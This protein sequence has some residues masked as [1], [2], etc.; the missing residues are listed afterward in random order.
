MTTKKLKLDRE[1][2][3]AKTRGNNLNAQIKEM[4][5]EKEKFQSLI[6]F[7]ALGL[8]IIDKDGQILFASSDAKETF[9]NSISDN[10]KTLFANTK[11][12]DSFK[13]KEEIIKEEILVN[14]NNQEI[15]LDLSLRLAQDGGAIIS[16]SDLTYR[17][18]LELEKYNAIDDYQS[19]FNN[20]SEG[21]F[22]VALDGQLLKANPAYLKL[23]GVDSE[24]ELLAV[25]DFAQQLYVD[26]NRS[27]EFLRQISKTGQ[28]TGF[29][30]EVYAYKTRQRIWISEDTKAI[31]NEQGDTLYYDGICRD[32]ST[33]KNSEL[34][35][36]RWSRFQKRLIKVSKSLLKTGF[37]LKFYDRLIKETIK[38]L[39]EIQTGVLFLRNNNADFQAVASINCNIS[40]SECNFSSKGIKLPKRPIYVQ[41]NMKLIKNLDSYPN[42]DLIEKV[43]CPKDRGETIILPIIDS[44]RVIALFSLSTNTDTR[45]AKDILEMSHIFI[46]TIAVLMKR[47]QLGSELARSNAEL[48]QLAN[49]DSLTMLPNRS[50]FLNNL[51]R[52][53]DYNLPDES[54]SLIFLD[55]DGLKL[56]NDSLGHDAGD[57][58]LKEVAER[59]R[60]CMRKTDAIARLGGDEFT[61]IVK[62]VKSQE[63]SI[64]IAKKI[65]RSFEPPFHFNGHKVFVSASLGLAQYP[66]HADNA[67]DL[68]K[69]ADSAM[70][71]SKST[72]KGR[73][74]FY[75]DSLK[76]IASKRM[77]LEQDLK[78]AIRNNEFV[79]FYQPRIE[80]KTNKI[81]SVEALVRWQHPEKG[82]IMPNDFI[83]LAEE[84]GIIDKLGKSV[85]EQ[86]CKQ[87]KKWQIE[88]KNLRVAV[89]LSVKQLQQVGIVEQIFTILKDNRLEPSQL[90]LEIT[91]SAAM[92][93]IE[94]NIVKLEN[95]KSA[96]IHIAIDDFGTAYSSLNY[97]KR[98]PIS[99]LKI[100]KSFLEDIQRDNFNPKDA[101]IIRSI[102]T[103]GKNLDL[104]IVAE[105]IETIDQLEFINTLECDEAQGYI[106]SKPL[107]V[108]DL[109]SY[110]THH[111]NPAIA[112]IQNKQT[113]YNPKLSLSN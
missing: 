75:N 93:N 46:T 95:L 90:E 29:E 47:I 110:L 25:K 2:R 18:N 74:S 100:D 68:I 94:A 50:F 61:I 84:I 103:L 88:G 15:T 51:Q 48:T 113:D 77:R 21:I 42:K 96:G 44:K 39:P 56:V 66:E 40:L 16:F 98:L 92:A 64:N 37:D 13:N 58:L 34:K 73:Y 20:I 65:L 112:G 79:L 32:I 108:D 12:F 87:A 111:I 31:K 102:A 82:L 10:I 63:D 3:L 97:L 24:E 1:F 17:Q 19:I 60:A 101:A 67:T 86:A 41:K 5:K 28:V 30:S 99:S 78:R 8:L 6:D 83:P 45:L 57:I 33:Q 69:R 53:I 91:E 23:N 9:A 36:E 85:L 109:E 49:Y 52:A 59:L 14:I 105:G 104:H 89:N 72:A 7:V 43:F 76:E 38:V 80:L 106:Y 71:H 27:Q 4:I 11:V 81:R 35:Q 70:Y 62:N 26:K 107:S 54:I 55:I 22:R